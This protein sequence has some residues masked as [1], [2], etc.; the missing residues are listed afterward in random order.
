MSANKEVIR[1]NI[2]TRVNVATATTGVM[3][4]N[5]QADS[6]KDQTGAFVDEIPASQIEATFWPPNSSRGPGLMARKPPSFWCYKKPKDPCTS[7]LE[8]SNSEGNVHDGPANQA[9]LN[10]GA[11]T[12]DPSAIPITELSVSISDA[13]RMVVDGYTPLSQKVDSGIQLTVVAR[14]NGQYTFEKWEDGSTDKTRIV[15]PGPGTTQLLAYYNVA[16]QS[17]IPALVGNMFKYVSPPDSSEIFHVQNRAGVE[18]I[19]NGVNTFTLHSGPADV[20]AFYDFHNLKIAFEHVWQELV[21][22]DLKDQVKKQYTELVEL[23][24]DPNEYLLLQGEIEILNVK[25]FLDSISNQIAETSKESGETLI[26]SKVA[27]EFE[28]TQE[29]WSSLSLELQQ[30]LEDI[31]NQII[32]A[33]AD[34]E[35]LETNREQL[36]QFL[37]G[38]AE[39]SPF[40]VSSPSSYDYD[41]KQLKDKISILH[42]LGEAILLSTTPKLETSEDKFAK[43]H[44]ILE[45]LGKTLNEPYWFSIYAANGRERSINFGIITTYRQKWEPVNYQVG[46]LVKTIPLAPKE[47]R[48]FTKRVVIKKSRAE[49]EV[50]N[51]LQSRKIEASETTRAE[52][53]IV[54][55]AQTKTNFKLSAEGG[56]NI[57][58]AD[59]RARSEFAKEASIESQEVKRE[60]REAVFKAAEEYKS[61]RTVEINVSTGEEITLEES[62]EISNPNDEISVTYLFYELQRRFRLSE[63]LHQVRPVILVAQ[64]FP[65][66]S[67]IDEDWIIAYDWILRRVILDD[68]FLPALDYVTTKVIGDEFSLQELYENIKQQREIIGS[69]EKELLNIKKQAE[70]RYGA[71]QQS[72]ERRAK[73]MEEEDSE[74][75]LGASIEATFGGSSPSPEAMQAREDAARDAYNRII[76]QEKD[77]EERLN[78]EVTALNALTETYTKNLSDHLNRRAQISRLKVHIK[79]NIMYYMQAIWSHEPPDQRFFRLHEVPVPKLIGKMTYKLETD[80]NLVPLPPTWTKPLKLIVKCKLDTNF[81]F[82]TLEQV[83]DLDNLLGFKGNYMVFPL[84]ES[85]ALTDFMM[86]PYPRRWK[87]RNSITR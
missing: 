12:N 61:D 60:F 73:A 81:E 17:P 82:Q 21:D 84:N 51:N 34:L 37:G 7:M 77:L 70:S 27:A 71:L 47:V 58:I 32:A 4:T 53:E 38:G 54:Q 13:S 19:Q 36:E 87:Q 78:R 59:V 68:S 41:I 45:S 72:I 8:N 39:H 66:P 20:P 52:R 2:Q 63:K 67:D 10:I 23:G 56:V 1:R 25:K 15:T 85:N 48:R 9:V 49:K 42:Q 50:E 6:F 86:T 28:I 75:L 33:R 5:S 40:S 24:L 65:K 62:G 26:P 64:E 83:A 31:T 14:D 18:E 3:L 69:L 76:K 35:N 22:D 55:K 57:E 46:Q 11:R 30:Q 80:P 79:S 74:G 43:Y 16:A 44:K 29:K